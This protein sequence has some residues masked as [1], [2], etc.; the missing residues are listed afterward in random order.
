MAPGLE[1]VGI[2][3]LWVRENIIFV[4]WNM[5]KGCQVTIFLNADNFVFYFFVFL[6]PCSLLENFVPGA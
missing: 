2:D 5:I 1:P 4:L 3:I 6:P